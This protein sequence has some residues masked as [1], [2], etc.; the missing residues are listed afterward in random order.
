ME[1]L[2]DKHLRRWYREFNRRFFS[3]ALPEDID[4]LYAPVERCLADVTFC[5]AQE[6]V[7]RINPRYAID[8]RVVRLTLLHE[9]AHVK[10]WPYRTHGPQFEAEMQRLANIGAFKGLW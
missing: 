3:A 6:F 9:M 5:P 2:S 1:S 8:T 10:L 7:L 4:L